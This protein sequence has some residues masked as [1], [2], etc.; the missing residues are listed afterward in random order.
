[1]CGIVGIVDT[2]RAVDPFELACLRDQM[3]R[4]GP[5]GHGEYFDSH[6]GLAM[7]RLAVI[8]LAHG[9]QPL[10]GADGQVVAFQ[11]GEIYNHRALR[12]ELEGEGFVFA[13]ASDTEVLAHGYIAWGIGGLLDRLDGMFALALLD[14][15]SG[16]LHLARDR[17]GEKPL[18]YAAGSGRFAYASD[19]RALSALDW[20]SADVDPLAIERY[21]SVHFAPG[22]STLF[23]AIRRVLPGER[24]VVHCA[25]ATLQ[26]HRYYRPP[27]SAPNLLSAEE[28]GG[29]VQSAVTS[30]LVADVPVGVFLSGGIDSSLIAAIAAQTQPG[31]ATFSMA[32]DD[33]ELDESSHAQRVATH[34]GSEHHVF[35]FND[36]HF[37]E[38]LPQAAAALDEPVGDQAI[39]PVYWLAK[40]AR[41]HVTVVLAG[42]G[43][44]EIFGGY[45]YYRAAPRTAHSRLIEGDTTLAGFPLITDAAERKGLALATGS[46]SDEWERNTVDWLGTAQG[47]LQKATATDLVSWLPDDLLIKLDRMTMA[48]G[49]E[50][51]A[52]YLSSPLVE[53]ALALPAASRMDARRSKILLRQVARRWLP[54]EIAGRVK[55]GFVLPMSRWLMEWFTAHGGVGPYFASRPLPGVDIQGVV[56][57]VEREVRTGVQRQRLVFALVILGEW[58]HAFCESRR[59]LVRERRGMAA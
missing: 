24:L 40:E 42:E 51:R 26:R 38:L 37:R 11:N 28:L 15:R 5:D 19:L 57:L 53:A 45:D 29:L 54:E 20:V 32:F 41:R 46:L 36:G 23:S 1:M 22:D 4:R 43:A 50:G 12:R 34:V 31:I 17:F 55:Q 6:I 7:R 9:G 25:S 49:L 16:L 52:P 47:G 14:R 8:D 48:H 58:Y 18:Y 21:L 56:R 39:L 30:R 10:Y 59:R 44:D 35:R 33:A 27:L 13:S 2:K 3:T